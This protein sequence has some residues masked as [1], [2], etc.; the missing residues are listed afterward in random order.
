MNAIDDWDRDGYR[1]FVNDSSIE[2][3][4]RVICC[5]HLHSFCYED[6]S[7]SLVRIVTPT[8]V[9]VL[10]ETVYDE[11]GGDSDTSFLGQGGG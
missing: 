3:I 2:F 8:V 6:V 11:L 10:F 1:H 7:F 4:E 9:E 5:F